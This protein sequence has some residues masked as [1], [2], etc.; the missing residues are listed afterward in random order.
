MIKYL[1]I[2]EILRLN[3]QVIEDYG[4]S[5]GV[6][7]EERIYSIANAPMQIVFNEEKYPDLI[8]KAAVYLRNIVSNHPFID[9][10]KR[11][12]ITSSGVFLQRNGCR[13]NANPKE[14]EDFVVS[15]ATEHL[16]I[17]TIAVW[18][19]SHTSK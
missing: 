15:I 13:L 17:A 18:L 19:K 5:H 9:G 11:T 7:D 2:E 10:N 3:F 8:T 12:Y 6:R 14:L 1:S 16:E 4:G